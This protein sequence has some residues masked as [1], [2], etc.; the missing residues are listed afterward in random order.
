MTDQEGGA[1]KADTEGATGLGEDFNRGKLVQLKENAMLTSTIRNKLKLADANGVY[2]VYEGLYKSTGWVV[3]IG[4]RA[5]PEI[6]NAFNPNVPTL[7]SEG[8]YAN[9]VPILPGQLEPVGNVV[10]LFPKS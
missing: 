4:P 3:Y 1:E 6:I 7:S 8:D 10:P 2:Q 5:K 9:V